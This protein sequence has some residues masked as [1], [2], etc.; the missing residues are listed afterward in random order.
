MKMIFETDYAEILD[1]FN[2]GW[3]KS[4]T[5]VTDGHYFCILEDDAQPNDY[6]GVLMTASQDFALEQWE[7]A[8]EGHLS[9]WSY[10]QIVN[11]TPR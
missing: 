2:I 3:E 5:L 9:L 1:Q 11:P 4:F 10:D 6:D 8:G 7:K